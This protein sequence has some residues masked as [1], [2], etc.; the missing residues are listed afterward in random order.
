MYLVEWEN[1]DVMYRCAILTEE[2]LV[3][4]WDDLTVDILSVEPF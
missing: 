1:I 4:L 3:A 2:E